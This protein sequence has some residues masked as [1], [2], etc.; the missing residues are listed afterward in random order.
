MLLDVCFPIVRPLAQQQLSTWASLTG[1]PA[2]KRRSMICL[3]SAGRGSH[4]RTSFCTMRRQ[5]HQQA[6]A[7]CCL[8][9]GRKVRSRCVMHL[10]TL[11]DFPRHDCW[12]QQLLVQRINQQLKQEGTELAALLHSLLGLKCPLLLSQQP[13]PAYTLVLV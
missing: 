2:R 7:L 11:T 10:Y 9:R 5:G 1:F 13:R 3:G 4:C 8:L 6:S 12:I